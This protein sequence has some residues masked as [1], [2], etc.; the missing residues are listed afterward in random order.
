MEKKGEIA[1]D[2]T[3]REKSKDK[4][5]SGRRRGREKRMKKTDNADVGFQSQFSGKVTAVED[6]KYPRLVSYFR[7]TL[8]RTSA[9]VENHFNYIV[10]VCHAENVV[11]KECGKLSW[12]ELVRTKL[13]LNKC[14][15]VIFDI[16]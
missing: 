4:N 6:E 2:D 14:V 3:K 8:H 5:E 13:E 15:F 9:E 10:F 1:E 16:R 7:K 12:D 11:V